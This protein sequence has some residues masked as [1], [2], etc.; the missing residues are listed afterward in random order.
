MDLPS[1]TLWAEG[2]KIA[3]TL[4]LNTKD[5]TEFENYL[6]AL[7]LSQIRIREQ[8]DELVWDIND[9][10]IYTPRKGYLHLIQENCQDEPLQWWK[11]IWKINCPAKSKL[12]WWSVL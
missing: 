12:F 8:E 10:G 7:F 2:W 1:T 11:K 9:S 5:S 3:T 6:N 4:N